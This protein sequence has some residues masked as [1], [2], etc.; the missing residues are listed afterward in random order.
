M[1][2]VE[3]PRP[4]WKSP[5]QEAV[6]LSGKFKWSSVQVVVSQVPNCSDTSLA[7]TTPEG[8]SRVS[9]AVMQSPGL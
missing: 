6:L 3:G 9:M 8:Y 2:Q 1:H 4:A 5:E 7:A